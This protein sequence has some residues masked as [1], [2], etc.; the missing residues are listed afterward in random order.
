MSADAQTG[1]FRRL[2]V[3]YDGSPQAERALEEAIGLAWAANA[4]ITVVVVA[5]DPSGWSAVGGMDGFGAPI[6]LVEVNEQM[7]RRYERLLEEAIGRIPPMMS[8]TPLL[9]RGSAGPV[10]VDEARSGSHDLV[11]MGSR[12]RGELKSMLLGSVSH[13][14]LHACPVPVLVVPEAR[15]TAAAGGAN[16]THEPE[17]RLHG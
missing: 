14:V 5:P 8:A 11:V 13:D 6:D 16:G 1:V 10:I 15:K 7:D 12:G 3:A 17:G 9:R 2:L 4:H